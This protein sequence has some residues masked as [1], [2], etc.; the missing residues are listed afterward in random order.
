MR[1]IVGAQAVGGVEPGAEAEIVVGPLRAVKAM[2]AA[3]CP[4]Q[5]SFIGADGSAG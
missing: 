1:S 3:L 5:I 4:A 2:P